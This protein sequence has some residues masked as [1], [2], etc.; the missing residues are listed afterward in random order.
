MSP[1]HLLS[2]PRLVALIDS[3]G[4][5]M[6]FPSASVSPHGMYFSCLPNP[7]PPITGATL[8]KSVR[9]SRTGSS[10]IR[11]DLHRNEETLRLQLSSEHHFGHH[12][13]PSEFQKSETWVLIF[14]LSTCSVVWS[15]VQI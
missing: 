9:N 8:R 1:E 11:E 12:R 4:M 7:S 10:R 5:P 14:S 13:C 6:K 3:S 15:V 2:L